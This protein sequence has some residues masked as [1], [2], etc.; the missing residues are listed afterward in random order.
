MFR[1]RRNNYDGLR[2]VSTYL[3][4]SFPSLDWIRKVSAATAQD[5]TSLA[6]SPRESI[7]LPSAAPIDTDHDY[8]EAVTDSH[9]LSVASA[10]S[11]AS[12]ATVTS[13][14]SQA[15]APS[16]STSLSTSPSSDISVTPQ[17]LFGGPI[18]AP[19][20]VFDTID[21]QQPGFAAFRNDDGPLETGAAAPSMDKSGPQVETLRKQDSR[22]SRSPHIQTQTAPLAAPARHIQRVFPTTLRCRRCSADLAFAAQVVSKGFTGRHGRA[23]LVSAPATSPSHLFAP[24]VKEARSDRE[25]DDDDDDDDGDDDDD[26]DDGG[27]GHALRLKPGRARD[28]PNILIG[29]SENRRLVTGA[30]VVADIYCAVCRSKLGWKYVDASDPAQRYKVGK[31]ILEIARLA[32][33]H[34]WEDVP[35]RDAR[36]VG[37]AGGEGEEGVA[38]DELETAR[39]PISDPLG[40]VRQLMARYQRL[41]TG[42]TTVD[43]EEEG[44]SEDDGDSD[45]YAPKRNGLIEFDSE[46]ED[47]CED[48]FMGTWD[49]D[50]VARRRAA[51]RAE[52]LLKSFKK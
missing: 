33:Y 17:S 29:R 3:L 18:A 7:A 24:E 1:I 19:F 35:L 46:D 52:L 38:D 49:A 25:D 36:G 23:Y 44:N 32:T 14:G 28:L 45:V 39:S 41:R 40:A 12:A 50:V 51:K 34:S 20:P 10:A 16:L 21:Y 2:P 43:V 30:H 4:P 15:T 9:R 37:G 47:E 11:S 31:F 13:T 5:A 42:E 8:F 6:T 27:G 26:D 48:I 22:P